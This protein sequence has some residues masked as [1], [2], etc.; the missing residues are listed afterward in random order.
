VTRNA[1]A[2]VMKKMAAVGSMSVPK[3]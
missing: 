2:A 3:S 1:T